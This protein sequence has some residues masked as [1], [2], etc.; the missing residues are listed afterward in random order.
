MPSVRKYPGVTARHSTVPET[1]GRPL[2]DIGVLMPRSSGRLLAPAID[3]PADEPA[4]RS[5]TRRSNSQS[6]CAVS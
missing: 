4:T 5:I 6:A 2:I 3:A 1:S